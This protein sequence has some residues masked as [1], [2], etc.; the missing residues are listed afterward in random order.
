MSRAIWVLLVRCLTNS[1]TLRIDNSRQSAIRAML[2]FS[3]VVFFRV[4]YD[5][6]N[7]S[8]FLST[9]DN[10]NGIMAP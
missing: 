7:E 6:S 4:S 9:S 3:V 1:A 5:I 8:L 2:H 10:G